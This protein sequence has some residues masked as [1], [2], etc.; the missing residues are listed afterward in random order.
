M[1]LIEPSIEYENQIR[2][3]RQEFLDCGD[4]MDGTEGLRRYENPKE[5]IERLHS[6]KDPSKIPAKAQALEYPL[7]QLAIGV[8]PSPD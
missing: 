3:Y 5:W 4:S 2:A 6:F 7:V 8:Q 1:K